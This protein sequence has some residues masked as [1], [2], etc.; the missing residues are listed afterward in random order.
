MVTTATTNLLLNRQQLAEFLKNPAA[1]KA[2]EQLFLAVN[3]D[4]PGGQTDVDITSG[5]ALQQAGEALSQLA[6]LAQLLSSVLLQPMTEIVTPDVFTLSPQEQV[7]EDVFIPAVNNGDVE[8]LSIKQNS[9]TYLISTGI[10]LKDNSAAAAGTLLNAPAIG[11]PT[12]WIA[13][14]D[15]G[16]IRRIPTW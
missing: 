3:Q 16:T 11:N 15:A 12:K 6:N 13:I 10:A 1:V 2:F 7:K 14:N 5:T 9:S 4:I 8:V